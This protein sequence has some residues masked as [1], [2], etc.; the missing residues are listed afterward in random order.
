MKTCL[1]CKETKELAAF[2]GRKDTKDGLQ[3]W[4]RD[5]QNADAKARWDATPRE[6]APGPDMKLCECGC[7]KPTPLAPQNNAHRGW[8]KGQPIQY[9]TVHNIPHGEP[10]TTRIKERF[11]GR[12]NKAAERGCWE[13]QGSK[14]RRGYGYFR[15]KERSNY[16]AHRLSW[17]LTN[18]SIPDGLEVCHACDNPACVNPGHLFLGTHR[19]NM[20][21][22]WQ[23][24]RIAPPSLRPGHIPHNT[25][26]THCIRGHELSGDN[27]KLTSDGRR[28]CAIC[29]RA[30]KA[31]Y[32]ERQKAMAAGDLGGAEIDLW[33]MTL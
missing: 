32:A 26:K 23:K 30:T 19:D 25:L 22:A 15:H 18:G 14:N 31:R 21:D 1:K 3:R 5:C 28:I 4:C 27:L 8:V 11:W 7:S 10:S 2:A 29:S 6:Q 16:L 33:D 24:G 12:V 20:I 9:I 17:E 13:W